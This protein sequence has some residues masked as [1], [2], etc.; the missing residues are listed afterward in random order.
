MMKRRLVTN[1]QVVG[2]LINFNQV[3]KY[4]LRSHVVLWS[5]RQSCKESYAAECWAVKIT[6]GKDGK[7]TINVKK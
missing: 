1:T 4:L 6:I 3:S 7:E 2:A 5:F